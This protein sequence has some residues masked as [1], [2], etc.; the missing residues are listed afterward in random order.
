MLAV[1]LF[2]LFLRSGMD[3]ALIGLAMMYTL[4]FTGFLQFAVRVSVDTENSM[5]SVERL[6]HY[7]RLP[8]EA[9]YVVPASQAPP[10]KW[11]ERGLIEMRNLKMRYRPDLPL[12]LKGISITIQPREKIGVCGR[13]GSGTDH[14]R[15]SSWTMVAVCHSPVA[16]PL[17]LFFFLCACVVL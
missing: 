8:T 10:A 6:S 15:A 12:V 16:H 1:G 13:T 9:A 14:Q 7:M 4:Q 2:G 5:T 11:P 17:F 3:S